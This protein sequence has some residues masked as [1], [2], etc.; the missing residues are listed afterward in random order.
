M[1]SSAA[2]DVNLHGRGLVNSDDYV[3]AHL[4]L[5]VRTA[6]RRDPWHVGRRC[7]RRREKVNG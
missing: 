1:A 4:L 3:I 2:M 6:Q 5:G 7:H